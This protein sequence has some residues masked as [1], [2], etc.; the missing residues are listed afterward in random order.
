MRLSECFATIPDYSVL[1]ED[2]DATEDLEPLRAIRAMER[3]LAPQARRTVHIPA[4]LLDQFLEEDWW[5]DYWD[6]WE[7]CPDDP[8]WEMAGFFEGILG[9]P[10]E[11]FIGGH[12]GMSRTNLFRRSRLDLIGRGE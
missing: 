5:E 7:G 12:S 4:H 10:P 11:T 2:A 3:I 9:C 8:D 6:P 1:R